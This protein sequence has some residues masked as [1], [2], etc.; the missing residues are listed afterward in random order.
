MGRGAGRSCRAA[1]EDCGGVW[2]G[3]RAALQLCRDYRAAWVRV[4]GPKVLP[5]T[6]GLAAG[7]ND[8][9]RSRRNCA[10]ERVRGEAG[11]SATRLCACRLG[12][13]VGREYSRK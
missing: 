11:G 8:L 2:A 13:C 9:R 4:D 5:S 3:E 10:E 1:E 6:R 7:T 12:D